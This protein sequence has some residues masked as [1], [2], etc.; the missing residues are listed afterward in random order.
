MTA[1]AAAADRDAKEEVGSG[2]VAVLGGGT[3]HD[4]AGRSEC[5]GGVR[6]GGKNNTFRRCVC[7]PQS[8]PEFDGVGGGGGPRAWSI[9]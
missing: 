6:I 1:A 5:G 8:P 4:D 7:A 2:V 3:V 9:G